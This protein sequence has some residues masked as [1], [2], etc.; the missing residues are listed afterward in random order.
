MLEF[1]DRSYILANQ[2]SRIEPDRGKRMSLCRKQSTIQHLEMNLIG[3]IST[4]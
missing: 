4:T 3:L 2:I 1:Q